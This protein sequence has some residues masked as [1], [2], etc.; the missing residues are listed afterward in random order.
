ME[1]HYIENL[2]TRRLE[3]HFEKKD[4]QELDTSIQKEIKS[5]CVF[6][7]HA[8]AW[9]SRTQKN[10][11]RSLQLAKKLGLEDHGQ[12]GEKLSFE[13]QQEIKQ[14]KAERRAERFEGYKKNSEKRQKDLQAEFNTMRKDWSWLTQ[15]NINSSAGRA[16]TNQRNKVVARY[17]KGFEEMKKQNYFSDRIANAERT[18]EAKQFENPAF[19]GRRIKE[20]EAQIR[21][22]QRTIESFEVVLKAGEERRYL[23]GQY[24]MVKLTDDE[25]IKYSGICL[26]YMERIEE[27]TDKL[28]FYQ[29]KLSETGQD[30]SKETLKERKATHINY[31]GKIYPIKSLNN[32]SVTILNWLS[33]G[34]WTRTI[35]YTSINAIYT[36]EDQKTVLD[37]DG[38]EVKPK[39]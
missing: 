31:R 28:N 16:F 3:L 20:C 24:Q 19:L 32:K 29:T 13:E 30:F 10:H 25:K 23:D 1:G 38:A 8:G 35:A 39:V 2:E 33:I 36:E 4:Y 7:R 34:S 37:R 9:V 18:A 12:K 17:E 11:Y 5:A 15:P 27:E 26:K 6:S 14:E 22:Y 21:D